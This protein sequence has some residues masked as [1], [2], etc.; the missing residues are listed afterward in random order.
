LLNS[1]APFYLGFALFAYVGRTPLHR[2]LLWAATVLGVGVAWDRTLHLAGDVPRLGPDGA[3]QVMAGLV[4]V[5]PL[6]VCLAGAATFAC[7]PRRWGEWLVGSGAVLGLVGGIALLSQPQLTTRLAMATLSSLHLPDYLLMQGVTLG[8]QLH[9]S[10][11]A[12]A[13]ALRQGAFSDNV[14]AAF[15]PVVLLPALVGAIRLPR[16]WREWA[17][18][19]AMSAA[20]VTFVMNSVTGTHHPR[21][22]FIAYPAIYLLAA[23]G[24]RNL[25]DGAARYVNRPLAIAVVAFV[26]LA[27][28]V[29][30]NA[31]LWG[32]W[33]YAN[34]FHFV[35]G[36]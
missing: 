15:P 36:K 8:G 25:F 18:A 9:T 22:L 20:L 17:L 29:P 5:A 14:L 35:V 4:A 1:L 32:D 19:V 3:G 6:V 23:S 11:G 30:A 26:V 24:L 31:S 34:R 13:G 2:L 28:A 27:T 12:V 16:R 33:S 10:W 21:I 7:L